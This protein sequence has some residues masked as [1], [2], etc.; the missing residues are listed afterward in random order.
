M[1][2]EASIKVSFM[3]DLSDL[4]LIR[5]ISNAPS[6][7]AA[8]RFLNV[9]PPAV[10][11]RLNSLEAQLKLK[12][13]DR[14]ASGIHLTSDGEHLAQ[15]AARLLH[16]LDQL[17]DDLATRRGAISGPLHVVAPFGF[18]RLH[19]A[20]ILADFAQQNP[21]ISPML[22]L[23]D[24]PVNMTKTDT[25]DVLIHVGRITKGDIVQ[26]KIRQ[27]R[28]LLCASPSYLA[29]Y[30]IP[31]KPKDL[32]DHKC[33]V[34]TEDHADVSLWQFEKSGQSACSV[35]VHP[36]FSSN[37]GEVIRDWA[38]RGL[39]IVERSEWSVQRD[40][41]AGNLQQ[42]LPDWDLPDADIVALLNP[43]AL[44]SAKCEGFVRFLQT[45]L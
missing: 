37:D 41:K 31:A 33:G 42:V 9:T 16:D 43:R 1:I 5:A 23:S 22:T 18:G 2:D 40:I 34:I 7:A 39:G 11:Q 38:L 26:R 20:G 21:E 27:N 13:V 8:A 44:R 28:R 36:S 19:I 35:R 45:R 15:R 10:S 29:E 3:V 30:G 6:L 4:K 24:A 17:H 25:W 14:S 32:M 12:L